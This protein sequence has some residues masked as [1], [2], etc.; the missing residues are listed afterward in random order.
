ME[1]KIKTA[2][3]IMETILSKIAQDYNLDNTDLQKY[4]DNDSD[5]QTITF[6]KKNT[7]NII[8]RARKQDGQRCTRRC[9]DESDF[10]GKHIKNQKYGCVQDSV[11]NDIISVDEIYYND[12]KYL[13]DE[14]SI[15]YIQ[16]DDQYEIVGKQMKSGKISFLKELIENKLF[17]DTLVNKPVD[18]QIMFEN[19]K[20]TFV[21]GSL[22][23]I[24]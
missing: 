22:Q 3:N 24:I 4:L 8:C 7:G 17:E 18:L 6:A 1:S 13:V 15:V 19:A 11:K 10:C 20:P 2:K 21:T 12:T 9:K 14:D 23:N 16:K 5:L